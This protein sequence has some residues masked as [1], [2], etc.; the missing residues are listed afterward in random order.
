MTAAQKAKI[1]VVDDELHMREIVVFDLQEAGY[2]VDQ[3]ES[4]EAAIKA[5]RAQTYDL[6]ISDVR[7]PAGSGVDLLGWV[8]DFNPLSPGF[9]FMTA[10]A[11]IS[12][13][14]ALSLG[15]EAFMNKPLEM[16]RVMEAVSEA[17]VH[18]LERWR[19]PLSDGG[20]ALQLLKVDPLMS[21]AGEDQPKIVLGGGGMFMEMS[22]NF[23]SALEIVRFEV[24][25][26]GAPFVGEGRVR[27]VRHEAS[28]RSDAGIGIEFLYLE[29]QSRKA[30]LNWLAVNK[31]KAYIPLG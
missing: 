29:D 23:P 8:K 9:I 6:V 3:A 25:V 7:M 30:F 21:V 26:D 18:R 14:E 12:S 11:D 2:S 28:T 24:E 15:A 5:V 16:D 4:G 13:E 1:L 22:G 31:P 10:F 17:V 19:T 27:W 20:E